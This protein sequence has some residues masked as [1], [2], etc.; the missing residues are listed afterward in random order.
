MSLLEQTLVGEVCGSSVFEAHTAVIILQCMTLYFLRV[1]IVHA[2]ILTS[3]LENVL[4]S[5]YVYVVFYSG[6][7][8][9]RQDDCC[10]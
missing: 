10:K 2:F 1:C 8:E 4:N 6:G 5:L 3:A 9:R 7:K